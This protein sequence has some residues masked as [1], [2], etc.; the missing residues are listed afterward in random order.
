M[1]FNIRINQVKALEWGL[2]LSEAAVFDFCMDLPA[3]AETII[4]NNQVWYFASKTKAAD[5]IPLVSEK[6]DTMYRPYKAL[7]EK[8]L[9]R[10]Q[11]IGDKDMIQITER[12]AE[13]NSSE[14]NPRL[15]KKSEAARK[16]IRDSS[17]N[18]PTYNNTSDNYTKDNER[19]AAPE[20]DNIQSNGLNQKKSAPAA[21][22]FQKPT[23]DE[24]TAYL[25]DL[26]IQSQWAP[27][28]QALPAATAEEIHDYYEA[29]GWKVGRNP[30][31]DWRAACR[32][33]LKNNDKFSKP[34]NNGYGQ[35]ARNQRA[36][37]FTEEQHRR[38][39]AELMRELGITGGPQQ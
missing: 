27:R 16:K 28:F 11:K 9:I 34:K 7:A 24:I 38:V 19:E 5:E 37:L 25:E 32:N 17:E 35:P 2:N 10:F 14:K 12:G 39:H 3:W 15:G 6:P 33:W 4:L 21:A 20:T 31:K 29:N 26:Y 8:G 18:F 13:W 36:P 30:M 22:R 23:A 1:R